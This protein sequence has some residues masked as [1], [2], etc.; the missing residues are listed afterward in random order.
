[1]SV[2]GAKGQDLGPG[3]EGRRAGPDISRATIE[4][5]DQ[6]AIAVCFFPTG[7]WAGR[8]QKNPQTAYFGRNRLRYQQLSPTRHTIRLRACGRRISEPY[9]AGCWV[10]EVKGPGFYAA[11]MVTRPLA[12]NRD[13]VDIESATPDRCG[14]DYL[15]A[16]LRRRERSSSSARLPQSIGIPRIRIPPPSNLIAEVRGEGVG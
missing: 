10:A 7:F 8:G 14:A 15:V 6:R 13:R 3:S 5:L 4:V 11:S 1:L 9:L 12:G 16:C 2:R